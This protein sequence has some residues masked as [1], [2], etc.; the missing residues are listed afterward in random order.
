[1][2][3]QA[4]P[5]GVMGQQDWMRQRAALRKAMAGSAPPGPWESRDL[6]G[7]AFGMLSEV[8]LAGHGFAL[9]KVGIGAW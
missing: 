9:N 2:R 7:S 4:P 1:M 5:L 6:S 3:D 8:A